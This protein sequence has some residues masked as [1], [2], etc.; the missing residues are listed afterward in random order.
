[1]LSADRTVYRLLP[2]AYCLL[3]TAYCL[4]PTAYR[5]PP[6]AYFTENAYTVVVRYVL[7]GSR[8]VDGK[9]GWFTESG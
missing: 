7:P 6:T 4:P 1:M 2:T 9:F 3:P 8:I 5:L